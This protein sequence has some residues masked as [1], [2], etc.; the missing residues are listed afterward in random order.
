MPIRYY[1]QPNPNT[2]DPNDQF[3]RVETNNNVGLDELADD[4]VREGGAVNRAAA[5][6]QINAVFDL[7]ARRVASGDAVNLGLLTV[8]PGIL[9]VF[10]SG[11]DR[12]EAARH[13]ITANL[14]PG[15]LL[16]ATLAGATVEF[17]DKGAPSPRPT[18]FRNLETGAENTTATLGGMAEITGSQLKFA[19]SDDASGIYFVST[20]D[21][22]AFKITQ[23]SNPTEGKLTFVVLTSIPPGQYWVEVRRRYGTASPILRTGRTPF[24]VTIAEV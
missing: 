6:G 8:R 9:G 23:V 15:P 18:L 5:A 1:L 12:F 13:R 19:K 21:P 3:A 22:A 7:I 24:S 11:T 16:E 20:L 14:Q 4:L 2:P 10:T 17:F